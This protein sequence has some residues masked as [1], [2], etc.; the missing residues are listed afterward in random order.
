QFLTINAP[1]FC[2]SP[3]SLAHS[4]LEFDHI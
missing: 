1:S 2:T 3:G 4:T